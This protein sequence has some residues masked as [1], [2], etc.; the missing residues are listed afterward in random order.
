MALQAR[1][2]ARPDH[3]RVPDSGGQ[4]ESVAGGELDRLG[5]RANQEGDR[6]LRADQELGGVMLVRGV[7]ITGTV[8]LRVRPDTGR[9]KALARRRHPGL[10]ATPVGKRLERADHSTRSAPRWT[11]TSPSIRET[12][13]NLSSGSSQGWIS[14][15]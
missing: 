7:P 2:A 8:A 15:S 1:A 13:T 9:L 5:V 4:H 14:D 11:N 12:L 6:A 3:G 10:P